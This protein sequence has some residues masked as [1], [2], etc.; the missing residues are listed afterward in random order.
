MLAPIDTGAEVR[1]FEVE[2]CSMYSWRIDPQSQLVIVRTDG[3]PEWTPDTKTYAHVADT[4]DARWRELATPI[5]EQH[6]VPVDGILAMICQES[7]GNPRAFRRE[8]DGQTGVGLLQITNKGL[9]GH[10]SDAEL[11]DPALNIE[12]GAGYAAY[13]ARRYHTD[14]GRP[15]WPKVFAAYNAG[16]VRPG[17]NQWNLFCYGSHVDAEVAFYNHI[18]MAR[19]DET[20]RLALEVAEHQFDL[21][22]ALDFTPHA[23]EPE[24]PG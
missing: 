14:D 11:F 7:Q 24:D 20:H 9:K 6:A 12:I 22:L 18:V 4:V 1:P 21:V 10:Y 2:R 15:D 16:S 3:G 5:A 23:N 19:L 8:P 13:Q 17:P